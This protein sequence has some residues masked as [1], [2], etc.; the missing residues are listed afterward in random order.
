MRAHGWYDLPD[1]KGS[2]CTNLLF[3]LSSWGSP[4]DGRAGIPTGDTSVSD[5]T[6]S[7][8][9]IAYL[10]A[11]YPP[12]EWPTKWMRESPS[13][14]RHSSRG[15]RKNSIASCADAAHARRGW[16]SRCRYI[17]I[18]IYVRVCVLWG[19]GRGKQVMVTTRKKRRGSPT[20]ISVGILLSL[21][22]RA[23]YERQ[24]WQRRLDS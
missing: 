4:C 16:Q 13:R 17:Y 12:R 11:R 3:V 24:R 1:G 23:P 20:F 15:L 18:C 10:A 7:G 5:A 6:I 8:F 14:R 19:E 9:H 21:F 22:K 2:L